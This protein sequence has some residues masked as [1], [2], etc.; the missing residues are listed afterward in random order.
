MEKD[1]A[2]HPSS[3][4]FRVLLLPGGRKGIVVI[5]ADDCGGLTFTHH[6]QVQVL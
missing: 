5:A 2:Y 1:D 3:F 6:S 4:Q